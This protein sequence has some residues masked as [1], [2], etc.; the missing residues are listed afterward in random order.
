MHHRDEELRD[1]SEILSEIGELVEQRSEGLEVLEVLIGLCACCL[2]LLLELAEGSSVCGFVL[3][4]ELEDLLDPLGA[5]LVAD[6]VE[7]V[8]FVLP[9]VDLSEGVG[10][11]VTLEG[12]LWVLLKYVLN[13]LSP[14]YYG[15]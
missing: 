10:V 5:K 14:G 11:L 12:R 15:A 1:L 4:K 13:L 8:G 2:D 9:E 3:L 6:G 7:V